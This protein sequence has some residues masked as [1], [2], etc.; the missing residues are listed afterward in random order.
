MRL[1]GGLAYCI[2][3]DTRNGRERRVC[4]M[5]AGNAFS[6]A[7]RMGKTRDITSQRER[8]DTEEERVLARKEISRLAFEV[9]YPIPKHVQENSTIFH[10]PCFLVQSQKKRKNPPSA[11]QKQSNRPTMH[12]K[13]IAGK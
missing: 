8:S 12:I 9:L 11:E 1:D 13:F 6:K 2:V 5:E 4:E 3:K 10:V 7:F